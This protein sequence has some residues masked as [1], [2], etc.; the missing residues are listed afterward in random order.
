[1]REHDERI[2]NQACLHKCFHQQDDAELSQPQADRCVTNDPTARGQTYTAHIP[3]ACQTISPRSSNSISLRQQVCIRS[4]QFA[5]VTAISP[6][7]QV[8][9]WHLH[10]LVL[11]CPWPWQLLSATRSSIRF[12]YEQRH[13]T[14]TQTLVHTAP[15]PHPNLKAR[16]SAL[17]PSSR[18][19][20]FLL[21]HVHIFLEL[22]Y[23]L[24]A[25]GRPQ[26]NR[27]NLSFCLSAQRFLAF[28][29]LPRLLQGQK[30]NSTI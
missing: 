6:L 17:Q 16:F 1:M 21:M 15:A 2:H 30:I 9:V 8:S 5:R 25:Q 3:I 14:A 12:D 22:L 23:E 24:H 20:Q 13:P 26:S 19:S 28:F 27:H 11:P 29:N 10:E 18:Q 4:M 7:T